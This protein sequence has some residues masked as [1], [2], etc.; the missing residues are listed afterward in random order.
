[1][2]RSVSIR[3]LDKV[4]STNNV[5][6]SMLQSCDNLSVFAAEEQTC[7]RGQGDHSWHSRK[8]ENLTFSIVLKFQEMTALRAADALRITEVI[9][10]AISSYLRGLGIATR[11]KWPNDIYVDN[12]KICGILIENQFEGEMISSSIIGI[13]LNLN[14]TTFP[15]DLPNPVSVAML[16]NE[17]Y[18]PG[19]ELKNL[20]GHICQTLE[21]LESAE[22]L[23]KLWN[24]FSSKLFNNPEVLK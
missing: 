16:T 5:A 8:G 22:G 10:T 9:T 23:N 7:G 12:S 24:A 13:G 6:R 2:N 1:M 18:D 21:L 4:D 17:S 19:T 14:Q 11:I 20:C 3:W 15:E